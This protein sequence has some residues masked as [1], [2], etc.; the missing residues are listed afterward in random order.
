MA[1]N[2]KRLIVDTLLWC[3]LAVLMVIGSVNVGA[4]RKYTSISLRY[5]TPISGQAA[6][7]ARI[8][9]IDRGGEDVFW[10][11]FWQETK[12]RLSVEHSRIDAACILFSGDA[13]LVWPARYLDGAAPGV[14]DGVGCAVSSALAWELWGSMDVVGKTVEVDGEARTVQGV[15]EE[16]EL[17]ALLSFRDEDRG[18]SFTAVELSGGPSSP[19]R[20]DVENFAIAAGLGRPDGVLMGTPTF[21]AAVLAALPLLMLA[22]Y[23]LCLCIGQLRK[24]SGFKWLL[25]F[26]ALIGFAVLLPA[27]LEALPDRMIPTHWSDFSFWGT[28]AGQTG[29]NLREYLTLTPQ[30]RDVEYMILLFRQIGIAFLSVVFALTVC[31]RWHGK[32]Q[33]DIVET[34]LL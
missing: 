10:P 27:L 26:I 2:V 28:L 33:H 1:G 20:N 3:T 15:F 19:A 6:Y 8:Y 16:E 5:D 24:R 32:R 30:L 23:G 18:Q 11:T 12:T 17:L 25:L 31:F 14:T 22:F 13:A 9:S 21:L 34:V 4:L 29:D 7:N